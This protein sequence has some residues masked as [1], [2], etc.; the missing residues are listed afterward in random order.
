[1]LGGITNSNIGIDSLR[2][3]P[4][5][6]LGVQWGSSQS[7]R[8]DEWGTESPIWLGQM[9]RGGQEDTTPLSTSNNFFAQLPSGPATTIVFFDGTILA[10]GGW[11][12]NEM[13]F[14]AKWWLPTLL[15]F[16]G[17]PVWFRQ[18]AGSARWGYFAAALIFLA[19]GSMWWSGRPVN[20]LGFMAAGCALAI[21]AARVWA[22]RRWVAGTVAVIGSGVLLARFATYYQPLAIVIGIPLV[23]ATTAFLLTRDTLWRHRLLGLGAIGLSALTWTGLVFLE[24]LDAIAAVLSTTYPGDRKSTGGALDVGMVFGATA[25]GWIKGM[26][27]NQSEISTAFTV[28][29]AVL[30]V[31]V[32]A[33]PWR[34]NRGLLA[35]LAT[36]VVCGAFWLSWGTLDWG[37][38]G[39]AIPVANRVPNT[40]AML[41]VGY[42]AI[43]AFSLFMSQ[44][45][46]SQR[47]AVPAAAGLIT[48]FLTGY[49]A[50]SLGVSALPELTVA[51]I[52]GSSLVAGLVVFA[53]VRWPRRWWSWV[54][55][56]GAAALLVA[57]ST[58]VLFGVGDLRASDT[59]Q[60]FLD[61]GVEARADG[62]TWASES[63]DVDSLMMA[64]GTPTLSARQ[65]MGPDVDAWLKLDPGGDH[66]DM[67][68][69]GGL[70]IQFDWTDGDSVDFT[71]PTPDII[72]VHTSPCELAERLP[73]F[74]YAVSSDPLEQ[75]CLAEGGAF[76]WAGVDYTVYEVATAG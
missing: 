43:L 25:L 28:L 22:D 19:P 57:A 12:P 35:A 61:W 72:V 66:E 62:H 5:S 39:A 74:R 13:L 44:W 73:G 47:W 64:T 69:R 27:V 2:E 15:L 26:T 76:R 54:A 17:L 58:P 33:T 51:M 38:L 75:P 30:A 14:A 34:G 48:A 1:M 32:A 36:L 71:Q 45:Q 60:R 63:Q 56:L 4:S 37:S 6:P 29:L 23:L 50:S 67:W 53:L 16:I 10:A 8:S 7:I 11:F 59:A 24:N 42:I 40:R 68:N 3:D 65:Q 31:L 70:H 21:Y 49:A 41:G 18:I 52:W 46:P 55:S 20:T 9:A